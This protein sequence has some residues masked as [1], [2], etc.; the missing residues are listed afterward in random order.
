MLTLIYIFG[1]PFAKQFALCYRTVVCPV[2]PVYDVG[3]LRPNGWMDQDATWYRGRPR[4]RQ[5]CVRWGPSSPT[6]RGIAAPNFQPTLLW[7][8]HPSQLLLALLLYCVPRLV[9][10]YMKTRSPAIAEG[11]RDAGVPVE[12]W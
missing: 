12:I 8:R 10:G 6:E 2:C 3:V 1:R 5:R 7:R 4:P 11:P 9:K